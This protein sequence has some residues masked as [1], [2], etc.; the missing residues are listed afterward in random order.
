[1]KLKLLTFSFVIIGI[2]TFASNSFSN[3]SNSLEFDKKLYTKTINTSIKNI[4]KKF[5][6]ST[7]DIINKLNDKNIKIHNENQTII[8]IALSNGKESKEIINTIL[9][10][11]KIN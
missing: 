2:F 11:K 1:M 6:L 4:S 3:T 7:K 9:S 8:E 10:Q 5:K